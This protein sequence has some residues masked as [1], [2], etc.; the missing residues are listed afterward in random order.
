[1][2]RT[3]RRA[4][5]VARRARDA[6]ALVK[7]VALA[8]SYGSPRRCRG[9]TVRVGGSLWR[10]Q[11]VCSRWLR[12]RQWA[13]RRRQVVFVVF[14]AN[15]GGSRAEGAGARRARRLDRSTCNR[16]YL[17]SQQSGIVQRGRGRRDK[18][19]TEWL[20]DG[21]CATVSGRFSSTR[22]RRRVAL[23]SDSLRRR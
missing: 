21:F 8:W 17:C 5:R 23:A 3:F 11:C 22:S 20:T 9:I 13:Q 7:A 16:A 4:A 14:A 19:H 2:T 6:A 15:R 18:I 12:E 10:A 1:M